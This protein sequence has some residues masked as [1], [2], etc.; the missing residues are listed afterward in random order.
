MENE[1]IT[2]YHDNNVVKTYKNND[3]TL[4]KNKMVKIYEKNNNIHISMRIINDWSSFEYLVNFGL[5]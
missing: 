5:F 2:C 1:I 3:N 4:A